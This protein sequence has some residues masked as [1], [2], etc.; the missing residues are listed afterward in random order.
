[1]ILLIVA[2]TIVMALDRYPIP[3]SEKQ[4]ESIANFLF[5]ICFV[6]EMFLK[7]IGLGIKGYYRDGFNVFDFI[8]IL[9]STVDIIFNTI[10]N[11]S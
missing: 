11:N 1:M 6:I 5:Y 7:L 3:D 4:Y 9:I 10:Y 2:N 8:I